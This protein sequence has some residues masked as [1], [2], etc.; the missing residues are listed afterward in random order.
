MVLTPIN[1]IAS[2][3]T[4]GE[5]TPEVG[6]GA[7]E[8]CWSD[9]HALTIVQVRK[10]ADSLKGEVSAVW[11]VRDV[12]K[13]KPGK[14]IHN[15]DQQGDAWEITP[16]PIPTDLNEK[17]ALIARATCYTKRKNG[18]W[19]RHGESMK[20]GGRIAIGYRSEYRDPSF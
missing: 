4:K 13:V 10:R 11:V 2:E 15:T 9:R 1:Q 6:M 18:A 14:T 3:A 12:A 20:N 17:L 19:V 7:T 8:L 5:P 16:T